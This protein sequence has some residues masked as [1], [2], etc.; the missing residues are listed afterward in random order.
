MTVE[1]HHD[2]AD[3]FNLVSDETRVDIV[4]ALVERRRERPDAPAVPFV[5][6]RKRVGISDSGNF[7]YH[8]GQL[9]G[10]FVEKSDAGYQL[11][12]T[13]RALAGAMVSGVYTNDARVEPTELPWPCLQCDEPV[14]GSYA[15]G[16]L[17][18]TCK[19]GHI[20]FETAIPPGA[21]DGRSTEELFS[22]STL[23]TQ[24]TAEVATAGICQSCLGTVE[25]SIVETDHEGVEFYGFRV[26]CERCGLRFETSVGF[27][28]VRH[29]AVVAFYHD[30]GVD[31]RT[32]PPWTLS[33]CDATEPVTLVSDDPLRVRV[34]VQHNGDELRLTL[35]E[36]GTVVNSELVT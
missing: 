11:T 13:G 5:E 24:W 17:S 15:D 36:G 4:R 19:N 28:V 30:R 2:V 29:P 27:A 9:R 3:V 25:R 14:F 10:H 6:L 34:D 33:F 18:A 20:V 16:V 7:N 26:T 12:V 32:R 31:I 22:L 1:R 21:V 8:L 35:D 23:T